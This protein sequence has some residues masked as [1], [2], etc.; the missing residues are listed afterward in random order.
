[1]E[2]ASLIPVPTG[3]PVPVGRMVTGRVTLR[4]VPGLPVALT[5]MR[6]TRVALGYN[7]LA[8]IAGGLE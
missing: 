5:T 4:V 2:V 7:G 1:V 8:V 6:T 3:D